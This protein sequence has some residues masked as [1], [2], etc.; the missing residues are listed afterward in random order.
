VLGSISPFLGGIVDTQITM[1]D[2]TEC[3]GPL[4]AFSYCHRADLLLGKYSL[5]WWWDGCTLGSTSGNNQVRGSLIF[6]ECVAVLYWPTPIVRKIAS[7]NEDSSCLG[8]FTRTLRFSLAPRFPPPPSSWLVETFFLSF[9]LS[10][11]SKTQ[12]SHWT[13]RMA[14]TRLA[15]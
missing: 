5:K 8:I 7:R 6:K 12:P 3:P 9:F 15:T 10:W 13:K 14:N 1:K 4:P 11:V 2:I